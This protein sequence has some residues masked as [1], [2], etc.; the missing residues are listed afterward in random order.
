MT[1]VQTCALPIYTCCAEVIEPLFEECGIKVHGRQL[2]GKTRYFVN[3]FEMPNGTRLYLGASPAGALIYRISKKH[4]YA[5]A[6]SEDP[7]VVQ[8]D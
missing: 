2:R 5:E 1:G 3:Y 8:K 7:A 4:S 6:V